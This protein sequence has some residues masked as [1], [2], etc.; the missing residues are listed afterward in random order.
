M[1]QR[2]YF[3]P[4]SFT[5]PVRTFLLAFACLALLF[6]TEGAQAQFGNRP[7]QQLKLEA[8]VAPATDNIPAQLVI[9]ATIKQDWHVYSVTQ[10][11]GS[12]GPTRTTIKLNDTEGIKLAG[13]FA[14]T[15]IPEIKPADAIFTVD[16][17]FHYNTITWV[18]PLEVPDGVDLANAT[19]TGSVR[20]QV[21]QAEQCVPFVNPFEAELDPELKAPATVAHASAGDSGGREGVLP[22]WTALGL[23]FLGGIV[24]NVMPC[25][26]PVIGLKILAFIEQG[27]ESRSKVFFLNFWYSAGVIAVWLALALLA[28]FFGLTLGSIFDR[29]E[30]SIVMAS[31]IFVM[32]LSFLGIWE[33]P[34][35]GFIGTQDVTKLGEREGY[36]GAFAKGTITTILA[37]PCLGPFMGGLFVGMLGRPAIEVYAIFFAIGLGMASPYLIIGAIPKATRFLPK[38]GAW[39]NTF[40]EVM[41]FFLIG[42]TVYLLTLLKLHLVVP[43]MVLLIGLGVM[44]WWIG[45]VPPTADPS[46]RWRALGESVAVASMMGLLAFYVI[47]PEMASRVEFGKWQY[48]DYEIE[49]MVADGELELK[50]ELPVFQRPWQ[51][52]T[53]RKFKWLVKNNK[54]ILIDFTADWCPTCKTNEKF[55][56]KTAA[57]NRLLR[58][59]GVYSLVADLSHVDEAADADAKLEELDVDGIPLVVIYRPGD[60]TNPVLL[61]GTLT[62]A[63]LHGEIKKA[64]GI[65]KMALGTSDAQSQ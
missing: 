52:Y 45:R 27:G 62:T 38:P 36:E 9:T 6:Q 35:P 29:P 51:P 24:L 19:L 42:T 55:V 13:P 53:H 7:A 20:G 18:A 5:S 1:T 44:C 12:P 61:P 23:A 63:Q 57:T 22:L 3:M 21:C 54:P 32:G 28:T 30:F 4:S 56:L 10:P 65:T 58:E 34:I 14:A 37:T 49:R 48:F 59:H 31:V 16:S 2:K 33:I 46:R 40:K 17:E 15:A 25:V 43:T 50:G 8:A 11:K 47:A 60:P 64:L 26:L 39:M 41:G